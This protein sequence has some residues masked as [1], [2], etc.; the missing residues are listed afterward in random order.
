MCFRHIK[1]HMPNGSTNQ[2]HSMGSIPLDLRSVQNERGPKFPRG[3]TARV[4][5]WV[6]FQFGSIDLSIGRLPTKLGSILESRISGQI[7]SSIIYLQGV[8]SARG[9][10][11]GWLRFGM[12]HSAAQLILP[13]SRLPKQNQSDWGTAKIQVKSK[14]SSQADGAPCIHWEQ[15]TVFH[16]WRIGNLQSW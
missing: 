6:G 10:G 2:N 4:G 12:F 7:F 3:Q 1:I 8:P 13:K 11:L 5:N 16:G 9:L 14:Q 15:L